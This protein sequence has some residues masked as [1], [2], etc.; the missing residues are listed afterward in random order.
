MNE[1]LVNKVLEW[2]QTKSLSLAAE[3]CE[4]LVELINEIANT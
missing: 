2:K 4:D 3:I 1:E